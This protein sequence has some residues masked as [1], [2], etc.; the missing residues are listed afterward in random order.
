MDFLLPGNV[1][2]AS[3]LGPACCSH[4]ESRFAISASGSYRMYCVCQAS[5]LSVQG[6]W[7]LSM[8]NAELLI[9]LGT[10]DSP[11]MYIDVQGGVGAMT[12]VES[13]ILLHLTP[14]LTLT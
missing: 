13:I 6:R 12:H 10:L 7:E 4:K 14:W 5:L 8:P 11:H 3:A 1:S 2:D 9:F